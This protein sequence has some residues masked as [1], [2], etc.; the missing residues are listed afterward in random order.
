MKTC[1]LG[2]LAEV[3]GVNRSTVNDW[4]GQGCPYLEKPDQSR[5]IGWKFSVAAVV[6]WLRK[7]DVDRAISDTSKMDID[8]A[9]LRKTAAEAALAELELA[10][11]RGEVVSITVV[12]E[13]V[14]EQLS[15]CKAKLLTLPSRA[16]PLVAPLIDRIE[17][18]DILDGVV[19]E[20]LDELV[21]YAG[22]SG[23]RPADPAQGD[24]E[25]DSGADES[26]AETDGERV[27]RRLSP[28]QRGKQRRART[29]DHRSQ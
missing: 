11:Q 8:E 4:L 29:V 28:P 2:E 19:R 18:R 12:T 10:K 27:G 15:A 16:A 14:G 17:C 26:A 1:N 5:G 6:A 24:T 9:R 13:I 22:G 7:R 25:D 20:V 21:G 3:L 23:E